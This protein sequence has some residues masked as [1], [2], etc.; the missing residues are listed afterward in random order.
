MV[1]TRA[2]GQSS[3]VTVLHSG[4][5]VK[6]R[7]R[8][9]VLSRLPWS[10]PV[11][12]PPHPLRAFFAGG[13]GNSSTSTHPSPDNN[14]SLVSDQ[15]PSPPPPKSLSSSVLTQ[16]SSTEEPGASPTSEAGGEDSSELDG[17]EPL[18][19]TAA[20]RL[21]FL[22]PLDDASDGA[23]PGG[24]TGKSEGGIANSGFRSARVTASPLAMRARRACALAMSSKTALFFGGDLSCAETIWPRTASTPRGADRRGLCALFTASAIFC[25]SAVLSLQSSVKPNLSMPSFAQ[26]VLMAVYRARRSAAFQ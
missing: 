23:A 15:F 22:L 11:L 17:S 8:V 1:L 26:N 10:P 12:D 20:V 2:I 5:C 25:I 14:P 3:Q 13:E 9:C 7:R 24:S 16:A 18:S 21:R 6:Q 4:D 19:S